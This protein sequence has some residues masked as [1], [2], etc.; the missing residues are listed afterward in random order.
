MYLGLDQSPAK[1]GWAIGSPDM[2]A[3]QTGVFVP[4]QY[5]DHY[6]RTLAGVSV[7]LQKL[8]SEHGVTDV[9]M[10][11][12]YIGAVTNP[13]IMRRIC[14]LAEHI[15]YVCFMFDIRCREV[16]TQT[17]RKRFI[18]RTTAP[19]GEH[20]CTA[21][22]RRKW[23]KDQAQRT[24]AVRRWDVKTDDEADAC[25]ILDYVLSVDFPKYAKKWKPVVYEE[26]AA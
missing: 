21:A 14:A 13:V 18:G 16:T 7:W 3:P 19:K 15:D 24:C 17:W 2:S 12:T 1:I 4:V 11:A 10:E 23:L 6:G 8:I 26:E 22:R 25:G 20:T 5:G 9:C